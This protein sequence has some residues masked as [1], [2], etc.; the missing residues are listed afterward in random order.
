M[1]CLDPFCNFEAWLPPCLLT[2]VVRIFFNSP[3]VFCG[4]NIVT[5]VWNNTRVYCYIWGLRKLD[6]FIDSIDI[7]VVKLVVRLHLYNIGKL[8]KQKNKLLKS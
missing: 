4:S 6:F 3:F 1:S 5:Q 2:L 7:F 8:D